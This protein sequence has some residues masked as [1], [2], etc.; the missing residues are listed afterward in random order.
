MAAE[1]LSQSVKAAKKI[2][3]KPKKS[4]RAVELPKVERPKERPIIF[5]T[6]PFKCT[7]N[8]KV[9]CKHEKLSESARS[10][11]RTQFDTRRILGSLPPQKAFRP[12]VTS[13][14]KC[15]CNTKVI[16]KHEKLSQYG[17]KELDK[18]VIRK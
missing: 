10:V 14:F 9:I 7:C 12:F 11:Q 13:P 4:K 18:F 1:K 8:T 15:T 3:R 6:S 5:A 16:C 17:K 2:R